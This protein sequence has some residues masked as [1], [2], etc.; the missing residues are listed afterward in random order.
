MTPA[1]ARQRQRADVSKTKPQRKRAGADVPIRVRKGIITIPAQNARVG[2][3]VQAAAA[4]L[5]LRLLPRQPLRWIR[6]LG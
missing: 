2:G 6:L 3:V 1:K 5:S 4:L